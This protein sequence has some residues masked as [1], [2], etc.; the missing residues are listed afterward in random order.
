MGA[1]G[2]VAADPT[3]LG[4]EEVA[5]VLATVKDLQ[6]EDASRARGRS[7]LA[8]K[9]Q[10]L[11]YSALLAAIHDRFAIGSAGSEV[12]P[13]KAFL[14]AT[15]SMGLGGGDEDDLDQDAMSNMFFE[16]CG[17]PEDPDDAA[18]VAAITMSVPQLG[19][20]LTH[21]ANQRVLMEHG[22]AT[23]G[24]AEQLRECLEEHAPRI[25][26]PLAGAFGSAG[27]VAA[28]RAA[29][30]S[31]EDFAAP[32][33]FRGQH[34]CEITLAIGEAGAEAGGGGCVVFELDADSAP[35][36]AWNFACLCSGEQGLAP[37]SGVPLHFLG[38]RFH[39]VCKGNFIQG[40]DIQFGNGTGGDSV[41]GG[42]YRSEESGLVKRHDAAGVLSVAHAGEEHSNS[43]QFFVLC[44]PQ[45]QLDGEHVVIGRVVEGMEHVLAAAQVDV[46]EDNDDCPKVPI[47]ITAC[48]R[49]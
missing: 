35:N 3:K 11:A 43:S 33:D 47:R 34:R 44:A 27:G 8:L 25:D 40:G 14:S 26:P 38:S 45:P 23:A 19:A 16:V 42:V 48:R 21:V 29:E 41:Y 2:S 13:V 5:K 7:L 20:V 9:D 32:A 46:D 6:F 28:A 36:A 15:V 10:L 39:R 30:R 17:Y 1:G 22:E 12:P 24:L 37:L 49:C 31:E 18:G 4:A